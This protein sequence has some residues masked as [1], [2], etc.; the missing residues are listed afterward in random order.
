[1]EFGASYALAE[2]NTVYSWGIVDWSAGTPPAAFPRKIQGL[3]G[4]VEQ[5][6][7]RFALTAN[8]DVYDLNASDGPRNIEELSGSAAIAQSSDSSLIAIGKDGWI[9]RYDLYG[10][11]G[12]PAADEMPGWQSE[13]SGIKSI[14]SSPYITLAINKNDKLYKWPGS[15]AG[16]PTQ[17]PTPV[18]LPNGERPIQI[19]TTM[20]YRDQ[21]FILSDKNH[22]YRFNDQGKLEP[23]IVPDGS[24][25]QI[26]ASERT[27]F[28][29]KSDGTVWAWGEAPNLIETDNGPIKSEHPRQIKGLSDIT[30]LE[31]GSDHLLALT[32]DGK[33][34]SLGSNMYGQL[35]RLPV[36]AKEPLAIGTW[37]GVDAF[38][39][40]YG[41]VFVIKDGDVW[42]WK[43]GG[44]IQPVLMDQHAV[45]VIAALGHYAVL[46]EDGRLIVAQTVE[47]QPCSILQT[48]S[49]IVDVNAALNG[50]VAVLANGSVFHVF[51]NI[52]QLDEKT[53]MTFEPRPAGRVTQVF[54]EPIPFALTDNGEL[55][56]RER[57]RDGVP[58]MKRVSI[59]SPVRQWSPMHYVFFDGIGYIGK[60]MDDQGRVFEITLKLE[61]DGDL[62]H[63]KAS[64]E[65]KATGQNG[66]RLT[67]GAVIG[68]DGHIQEELFNRTVDTRLPTG[69]RLRTAGSLYHFPIEGRSF[70]YHML[71]AEDGTLY[72]LGNLPYEGPIL[73]PSHVARY[74]IP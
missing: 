67:G 71:L 68:T 51:G 42:L 59:E 3:K 56:Y 5:L 26:T 53:E 65:V 34:L 44:S 60:A 16:D 61:R 39:P 52:H 12:K 62:S 43:A 35:G 25:I 69:I 45:K 38:F 58:V 18:E 66:V 74:P 7:G 37:H 24:V 10:R 19:N 54:G 14:A 50:I 72:W 22:W 40:V 6:D 4:V 21:A 11:N 30:N 41:R 15:F 8:G 1:M 2:D 32:K 47:N 9:K 36:Y 20:S 49:P 27:T 33:V 70:F 64:V 29:L 13:V 73:T 55:Y 48:K 31:A 57:T 63:E 23:A 28:A 46:T 17:K